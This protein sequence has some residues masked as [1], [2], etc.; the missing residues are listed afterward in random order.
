MPLYIDS[1]IKLKQL[2][3][4]G[5][6]AIARLGEGYICPSYESGLSEEG[7]TSKICRATQG[8]EISTLLVDTVRKSTD[9]LASAPNALK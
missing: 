1:S 7:G 4:L 6:E 8:L 2:V 5:H 9:V 3:L